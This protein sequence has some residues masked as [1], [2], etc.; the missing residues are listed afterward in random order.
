M[1]VNRDIRAN[2]VRLIDAEGKQVGVVSLKT[3]LDAATAASL[4]LV[5]IVPQ[6]EP[7]VCRIMNF[8]KY[9]FE[10]NKQ[11]QAAKK[12]QKQV[13]VKEIK[14][15][16]VTEEADYQVKLRNLIRFLEEGDKAKVT[17]KFR[18]RELSH[19]ELGVK[20]MQRIEKDLA[21]YAT[22]EQAVKV[23]GRQMMMMF[24]PKKKK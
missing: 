6:A 4:D 7:P 9:L 2:E 22:V 12:K 8:G 3:A 20:V 10:Q 16:P 15:R 21:D 24:G 5:E 13:Q 17:L 23:E 18:G 14:L 19:Q 1:R 11:K